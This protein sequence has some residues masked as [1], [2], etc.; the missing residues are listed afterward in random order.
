GWKAEH[1][2]DVAAP[3][4]GAADEEVGVDRARVGLDGLYE[5]V[6]QVE[7]GHLDA[8]EDA[9]ALALGEAAEVVDGRLRL[10]PATLV[11]VQDGGD[12]VAVPVGEDRLHV[13]AARL[14]A[15]DHVGA[16]ADLSLPLLD[17]DAVLRLHLRHRRD[18]ADG[19]VA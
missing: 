19:V 7:A 8:L 18:V 6:V 13:L 2:P 12:A 3:R 10:G 5:A 17:R 1:A 11:L 16:V 9:H 4:P 14:L 15:E